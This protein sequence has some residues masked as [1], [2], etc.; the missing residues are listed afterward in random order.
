M[1]LSDDADEEVAWISSL[2]LLGISFHKSY[3]VEWDRFPTTPSTMTTTMG[4]QQV[5]TDS[6]VSDAHLSNHE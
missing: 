1:R 2:Q 5:P 3:S 6:F 4:A